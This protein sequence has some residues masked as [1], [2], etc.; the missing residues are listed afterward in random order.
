MPDFYELLER[1]ND[2]AAAGRYKQAEEVGAQ[3][4]AQLPDRRSSTWIYL[5]ALHVRNNSLKAATEVLRDA[6]D[7]GA[8]WRL[9]ALDMPDLR[10][11]REHAPARPILDEAFRRIEAR[12]FR[13]EVLV[14]RPD[15]QGTRPLLFHLHGAYGN[16]AME[17]PY[18][19][20]ATSLGWIVAAGQST[21]PSAEDRFCWDPPPERIRRDL[22]ALRDLLP[23][24]DRILL[25]GFSQGAWAALRA[26]LQGD[27]FPASSAI[28]VGPFI[29]RLDDLRRSA[30]RL[31]VAIV[32]G[33]QDRVTRD[34]TPLVEALEGGGHH[35]Q[36]ERVA[37]LGHDYPSDFA[38]RLP[39]L[40]HALT[41]ES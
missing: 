38:E 39:L 14:A 30:R 2:N 5:A 33:E 8:L 36:I 24:H 10:P 27:L 21:Q 32:A 15:R 18:F 7:A 31:R 16:A 34:P 17:L 29:G 26:A 20:P 19:E 37:G 11:L 40:L 35:V 28:L 3:M 4:W 1:L 25:T 23:A 9:S 12:N 13:P 6:L 41:Q 22:E